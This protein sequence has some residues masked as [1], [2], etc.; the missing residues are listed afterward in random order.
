MV[1]ASFIVWLILFIVH[2]IVDRK[3]NQL[4]IHVTG[5]LPI[6]RAMNMKHLLSRLLCQPW[7]VSFMELNFF[8]RCCIIFKTIL[9][10]L[11][12]KAFFWCFA[13]VYTS[14]WYSTELS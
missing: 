11:H 1:Y 6:G 7:A 10:H 2:V 3:S 5:S 8:V 13:K 12:E 14:L 4:E 9:V